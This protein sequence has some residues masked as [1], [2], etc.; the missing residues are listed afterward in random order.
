MLSDE[1]NHHESILRRF[2]GDRSII[3]LRVLIQ[4]FAGLNKRNIGSFNLSNSPAGI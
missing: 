3:Y 4:H 2:V 1:R